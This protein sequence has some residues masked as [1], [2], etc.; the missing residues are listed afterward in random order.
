MVPS[1]LILFNDPD[2][3]LTHFSIPIGPDRARRKVALFRAPNAPLDTSAIQRW[4]EIE[5]KVHQEDQIVWELAQRG[6]ASS[7]TEEEGVL[8]TR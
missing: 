8:L 4:R 6:R 5:I 1:F 3:V 2:V 7:V